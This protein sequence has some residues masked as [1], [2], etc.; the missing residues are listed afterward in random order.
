MRKVLLIG[1]ILA[2]LLLAFPQGVM[3]DDAIVNANV[4]AIPYSFSASYEGGMWSLT[5]GMTNV[6]TIPIVV[7]ITGNQYWD[8]SAVDA[9]A[10]KPGT[11]GHMYEWNAA[12]GYT[13]SEELNH[14]LVITDNINDYEISNTAIT[15]ASGNGAWVSNFWF[16][17]DVDAAELNLPTNS[18]H[19]VVEITCGF[20]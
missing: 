20:R 15:I 5:T 19:L 13:G 17:Q 11:P 12:S 16:S 2:I 8:I 10:S 4:A 6:D 3:A 14:A 18:Y 9:D 7:T 1:F